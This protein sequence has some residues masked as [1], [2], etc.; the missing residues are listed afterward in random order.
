M[1]PVFDYRE[2]CRR[3]YI[4]VHDRRPEGGIITHMSGHYTAPF[5]SFT[6]AMLQGEQYRWPLPHWQVEDD[7]TQV[8]HLDYARTE[9]TGL[10]LGVAPVFLP[11][12]SGARGGARNR[13]NTEH[14]LAVTRL[15]DMNVWPIWCDPEPVRELWRA[16]DRFG[17]GEADVQFLPYWEEPPAETDAEEVLVSG[18]SRP[19]RGMLVVSNFLGHEDRTVTVRPNGAVLGFERAFTATDLLTGEPI[20]V[21]AGCLR[22]DLPEGRARYVLLIEE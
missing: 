2:A 6:D 18:Y 14:L 12:Y 10:N 13:R 9:L 3:A 5:L 1:H 15:H 20:A 11:E 7:Y 19:G 4:A 21:E 17:I 22:L 16:Q 8:L